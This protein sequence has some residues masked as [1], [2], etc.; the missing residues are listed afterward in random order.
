MCHLSRLTCHLSLM[1]TAT[2]QDPPPANSPIM[3]LKTFQNAIKTTKT[4]TCLEAY[5]QYAHT[6]SGHRNLET[7]STQKANSEK[8]PH[9]GD[10]ESCDVRRSL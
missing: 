3:H 9:T 8:I 7:E 4:Q 2:P 1:L 5:Q 6:I 10:T